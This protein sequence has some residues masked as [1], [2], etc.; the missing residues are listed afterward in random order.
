MFL[1][2]V[3]VGLTASNT[4]GPEPFVILKWRR[5]SAT[6]QARIAVVRQPR[7]WE[8]NPRTSNS[9]GTRNL[10]ATMAE[11]GTSAG[12]FGDVTSIRLG[13]KTRRPQLWVESR[14]GSG[15]T[16]IRW[17]TAVNVL[18][19]SNERWRRSRRHGILRNRCF[20]RWRGWPR[21]NGMTS[22]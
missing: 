12:F 19:R 21:A 11:G 22:F 18:I 5:P 4:V 20:L 14:R 2:W 15:V 10:G 6:S 17:P 13:S 1:F 9:F 3:K 7:S 8:A 16:Y